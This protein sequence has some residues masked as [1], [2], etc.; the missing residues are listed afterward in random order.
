MVTLK[1]MYI[2]GVMIRYEVESGISIGKLYIEYQVDS[3]QLVWKWSSEQLFPGWLVI[4]ANIATGRTT[5][6]IVTDQNCN[7]IFC[8]LEV[9][10]GGL[11]DIFNRILDILALI[12]ETLLGGVNLLIDVIE[13]IIDTLK[14]ILADIIALGE[15]IN[16]LRNLFIST[17]NTTEAADIPALPD[18]TD[19][20]SSGI[21]KS[22]WGNGQYHFLWD[23]YRTHS[24]NHRHSKR[25]S[26]TV[27]H[28][29]HPYSNA[30]GRAVHMR[31]FVVC[32]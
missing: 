13:L 7:N 27:G 15:T 32:T 6:T 28:A 1:Q 23:R 16:L 21:C 25:S 5:T 29:S 12:L 19:Y 26:D 4:F 18:C 8:V 2:N 24:I 14:A 31:H 22:M 11:L 17:W 10:F 3:G 20:R 30:C 9:F